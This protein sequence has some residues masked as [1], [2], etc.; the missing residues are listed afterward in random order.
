MAR[1]VGGSMIGELSGKLGGNVFARNKGGAYIRQYVVPVDPKSIAQI[2]ARTKF[3]YASSSYHSLTDEEKANWQSF[4]V[5]RYLPKDG[6]NTGQ[7]S[8]FNAFT[9]LANT[10]ANAQ[11][12]D[13]GTVYS[14]AVTG[15]P[16]TGQVLGNFMPSL[17]PPSDRIQANLRDAAGNPISLIVN[18]NTKFAANGAFKI[19]LNW[20]GIIGPGGTEVAIPFRDAAGNNVGF[21]LYMSNPVQQAHMFITNPEKYQVAALKPLISAT[22]V[23]GLATGVVIEGQV[24]DLSIFKSIPNTGDYVRLTVY[25]VSVG[26]QAIRIGSVTTLVPATI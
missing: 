11:S 3:G 6:I 4:A 21:A 25:A 10:A 1:I 8:G 9:A 7:Y 15:L 24:N 5:E 12:K 22:G 20:N 2:N 16:L 14:D 23:T 17:T 19:V 13:F 26:G 18:G